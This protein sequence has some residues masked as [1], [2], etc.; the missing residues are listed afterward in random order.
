MRTALPTI[1]ALALCTACSDQD[2]VIC[3][4]NFEPA[5]VVEIHDSITG[6]PLAQEARGAVREGTFIDSLRPRTSSSL[7]A[8]GERPGT[9]VVTVVHSGY[10]DWLRTG[11]QVQDGVCHVQTVTLQALL[12][13]SP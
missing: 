1:A 10:A 13:P 6:T 12:Q 2:L 4:L 7:Q 9:Y 8:A 5:V 3:T 11:V